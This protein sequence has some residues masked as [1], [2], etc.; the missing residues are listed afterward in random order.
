MTEEARREWLA[1]A[2]QTLKHLPADLLAL[3]CRE[4]R[5]SCD[6][7]SKLVPTIIKATEQQLGWRR[8]AARPDTGMPSLPPPPKHVLERRGEPMNEIDTA[9]LNRI[10]E[11]QG[12][13]ARYRTDGSRYL[14]DEAA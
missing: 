7:P 12:A 13:K 1:V 14:I 5:K 10:L 2:W 9:E 4:A 6:H 3:G 8:D 11:W